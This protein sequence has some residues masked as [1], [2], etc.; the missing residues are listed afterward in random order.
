MMWIPVGIALV[1]VII[2]VAAYASQRRSDQDPA[3]LFLMVASA[4]Y[5]TGL[6]LGAL[7][8]GLASPTLETWPWAIGVRAAWQLVGTA[9]ILVCIGRYAVENVGAGKRA[10]WALAGVAAALGLVAAS[11][12]VRDLVSGPEVLR[13]TG[14][15]KT[16][17]RSFRSPAGYIFIT[18]K[19]RAPDGRMREIELAGWGANTAEDLLDQC[20]SPDGATVTVLVHVGR[21]LAVRCP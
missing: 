10:L 8:T 20:E 16:L 6:L 3:S 13:M 17:K 5:I 18:L 21:V 1:V 11:N 19:G 4:I 9:L 2:L 14:F 15:E 7:V 12:P